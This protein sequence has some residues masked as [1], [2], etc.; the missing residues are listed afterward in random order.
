[1]SFIVLDSNYHSLK[2]GYTNK[3]FRRKIC[4]DMTTKGQKIKVFGYFNFRL[5]LCWT[6]GCT[7]KTVN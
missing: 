6:P 3:F 2:F 1:M 7:L 5:L 4:N